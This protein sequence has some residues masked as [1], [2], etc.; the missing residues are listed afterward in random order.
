MSIFRKIG[1]ALAGAITG[2]IGAV[3][4]INWD[5]VAHHPE[6]ILYVA[7]MVVGGAVAT[8]AKGALDKPAESP[9]P[10]PGK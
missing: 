6:K 1:T 5:D 8:V 2:A 4:A 7:L 3:G 10:T 9:P